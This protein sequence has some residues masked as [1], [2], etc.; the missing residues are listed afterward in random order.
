M[1]AH[2][3]SKDA[4]RPVTHWSASE[5]FGVSEGQLRRSRALV[6]IIVCMLVLFGVWASL[7]SVD[8]VS[9]GMGKVV[10]SSR[11]QD[12]Q[13]LDGGI[14]LEILVREGDLV[15]AG[16]PVAR[17]DPTRIRSSVEESGARLRANLARA[18]RLQAEVYGTEPVF[19]EEVAAES[20]LI[21]SETE[22]FRQ[23]RDALQKT[24]DGLLTARHL[25]ERE[26]GM[27]RQ[28]VSK[29][30]ASQVDVL[31]LESRL[32]DLALRLDQER[33]QYYVKA[34]EELA[35]VSSSIES[36]RQISR[37]RSDMLERTTLTAPV[38]GLVKQLYVSTEGGVLPPNGRLLTLIPV[39]DQLLVET[40]VSPRDIAYIRP[41][42]RATVKITALDYSIYGGLQ[43]EVVQISPD[44]IQDEVRRDTY[45]YRVYIKT[46][47]DYLENRQGR[48]FAIVPGMVAEVDI[49][50]GSKTVLDYLVKPVNKMRE[51]LRER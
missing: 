46:T 23:R 24:V 35:E 44:T 40:Q 34:R 25:A 51:A 2:N 43:G 11:E 6:W 22:L 8:E 32:N 47:A 42:L 36:Q 21:R 5:A 30:A 15:E 33:N 20:D 4:L 38:R 27:I 39:D 12:V 26:L 3:T 1:Q 41:G 7:F 29:G 18:A 19:P 14:L 10:A 13:S 28:A 49:H 50:T 9:K 17:L 31:R 16:Q 37:S 48:R 45:Y